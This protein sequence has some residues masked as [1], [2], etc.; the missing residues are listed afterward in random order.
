MSQ[1]DTVPD[2]SGVPPEAIESTDVLKGGASAI[3]GSSA[4]GGVLNM[5]LLKRFSGVETLLSYGGTTMGDGIFK[6]AAVV[7]GKKVGNLSIVGSVSTSERSE[8]SDNDRIPTNTSDFRK[9][10]G[11]DRRLATS[12]DPMRIA[13]ASAPNSPLII[14]LSRFK[15]GQTGT[16]A[17]DYVPWSQN[18]NTIGT[19]PYT[20]IAK[21]RRTQGHWAVEYEI[22]GKEL[23][24]FATGYWDIHQTQD[25]STASVVTVTVPANNPYNPFK[26]VATVFYRFN[27]TELNNDQAN[28]AHDVW[29]TWANQGVFGLRGEYKG[30]T[31]DMGWNNASLDRTQNVTNDVA[32][33]LAQ[34][35]VNR[36]DAGALNVFGYNANSQTQTAG[37]APPHA[38]KFRNK[39]TMLDFKVTGPIATLPTGIARFAL[40]A[41]TRRTGYQRI[42]DATWLAYNFGVS[43]NGASVNTPHY[44]R[45]ADAYFGEATVPV[46]N[47]K[48]DRLPVSTMELNGAL[49]RDTYSDFKGTTIH[50]FSASTRGLNDSLV[51]RVLV[52]QGVRAPFAVDLK[53]PNASSILNGLFDPVRGGVFPVTRITGGNL[54]LKEERADTRDYGV[55]Y[56]PPGLKGVTIRGDYWS[57]D[58][59]NRIFAPAPQDILNGIASGG[60]LS[61]DPVTGN[62]TIDARSVN[63]T[64]RAAGGYDFG[65]GYSLPTAQH[66][67][68]AFDLTGTYTTKLWDK[69]SGVT[70]VLLDHY[71]G[72]TNLSGGGGGTEPIPRL[73]AVFTAFWYYGNF[74]AGLTAH[75]HSGLHDTVV[76]LIDRQSEPYYTADLQCSYNFAKE[77]T[78]LHGALRNTRLSLGVDNIWNE[79]VPFVAS[80]TTGW[81][82]NISDPRGRYVYM[83]VRKK[84]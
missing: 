22:F 26:Q 20:L 67:R 23:V 28:L 31:Y 53:A 45:T 27:G 11:L 80:T 17:S 15:P 9:W 18:L 38:Y 52:A 19:V 71:A 77:S 82:Q 32:R 60:T 3:Y 14:D 59:K 83:S 66:G 58:I 48:N 56:S 30:F 40:G 16:S 55:V 72:S 37:I 10:G 43:G 44:Q 62:V 46:L 1:E 8:V 5:K 24:A 51:L 75:H 39:L 49:R 41:E 25:R 74:N 76:G 6:R 50:S 79:A 63:G 54:N 34:A 68:F 21:D 4:V 47:L 29:D 69:S 36:T 70:S 73:Q 12:G 2:I 7:F 64:E 61:R 13:L 33:E 65:V 84:L 78:I 81:D 42:A 35:A 57:V